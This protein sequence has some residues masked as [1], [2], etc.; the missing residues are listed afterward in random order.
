MRLE[1]D[2]NCISYLLTLGYNLSP[3]FSTKDEEYVKCTELMLSKYLV[4]RVC[5]YITD[6]DLLHDSSA[7]SMVLK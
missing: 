4:G 5:P 7:D 3:L 1:L 6:K 2:T